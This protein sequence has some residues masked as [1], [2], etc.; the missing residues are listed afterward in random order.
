[1]YIIY[2][3]IFITKE[4]N[5]FAISILKVRATGFAKLIFNKSSIKIVEI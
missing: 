5:S 1:M 2:L 3:I 4:E